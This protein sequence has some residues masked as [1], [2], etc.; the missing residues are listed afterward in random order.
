MGQ[1][2]ILKFLINKRKVNNNYYNRVEIEQEAGLQMNRVSIN[3][4]L[5]SLVA[6]GEVDI[7]FKK[8]IYNGCCNG[9][10]PTYRAKLEDTTI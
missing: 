1:Q 3:R 7:K 9:F 8:T 4:A 6:Y 10:K 2:E 5:R